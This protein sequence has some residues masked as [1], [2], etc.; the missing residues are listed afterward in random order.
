MHTISGGG[1]PAIIRKRDLRRKKKKIPSQLISF[2][3]DLSRT[4]GPDVNSPL[5][6]SAPT[7]CLSSP[8]PTS[9]DKTPY[10]DRLE[11]LAH[12]QELQLA[13]EALKS[14][15]KSP[16]NKSPSG[17]S[18]IS[19]DMGNAEGKMKTGS[20]VVS[21][22]EDCDDDLQYSLRISGKSATYDD[23][24]F[25]EASFQNLFEKNFPQSLEQTPENNKCNV[26]DGN[27]TSSMLP[28]TRAQRPSS[29]YDQEN[30]SQKS[31]QSNLSADS[32]P[33][34]YVSSFDGCFE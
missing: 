28:Q 12:L 18:E 8:A 19:E 24:S 22:L 2:D 6:H 13:K 15:S 3:D 34:R 14:A 25:N 26:D 20:E 9:A 31:S 7:T 21:P 27:G 5:Y 11:K 23:E 17:Q 30:G 32:F 29:L 1:N 4:D 16:S 33:S 10:A